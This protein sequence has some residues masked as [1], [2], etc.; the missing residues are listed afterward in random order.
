MPVYRV[1][2]EC[3]IG[4]DI[5]VEAPDQQTAEDA[6]YRQPLEAWHADAEYW[7]ESDAEEMDE[8]EYVPDISVNADGQVLVDTLHR[9]KSE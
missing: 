5:F 3:I 2:R 6:A 9:E 8:G 4:Y 7:Q 1:Q